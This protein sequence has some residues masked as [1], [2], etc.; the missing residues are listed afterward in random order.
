LT[1]F[2][3]YRKRTF[4]LAFR[5]IN[6]GIAY[7]RLHTTAALAHKTI[8]GTIL[9]IINATGAILPYRILSVIVRYAIIFLF[10]TIIIDFRTAVTALR[11]KITYTITGTWNFTFDIITRH[12]IQIRAIS[13]LPLKLN[14]TNLRFGTCAYIFGTSFACPIIRN[15]CTNFSIATVLAHMVLQIA[16]FA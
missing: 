2:I 15:T 1:I 6:D 11:C 8:Y 10:I 4:I 12:Q 5:I 9:A 13:I 16:V 7:R 3:A 14:A